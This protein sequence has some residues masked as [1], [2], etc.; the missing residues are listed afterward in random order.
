MIAFTWPYAVAFWAVFIWAFA[1]EFSVVLK[2][3][4][5]ASDAGSMRV[6][7]VSNQMAMLLGFGA[8]WIFRRASM[9]YPV[10]L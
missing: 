2:A 4:K 1:P 8:P 5:S 9:P 6:I 7:L 10:A 3:K